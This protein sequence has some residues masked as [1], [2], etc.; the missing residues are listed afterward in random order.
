MKV[1]KIFASNSQE[2]RLEMPTWMLK[3]ENALIRGKNLTDKKGNIDWFN[4]FEEGEGFRVRLIPNIERRV[5][6]TF[7][8]IDFDKHQKYL[9]QSNSLGFRGPDLEAK[10]AADTYRVLIFGDSSSFGWGVD[11]ADTFYSIMSEKLSKQFPGKKFEIANFAI[12]GD[13]SEYGKLIAGKYIPKYESDLVILGFG[14]NDAKKTYI[15]HKI[16]VEKFKSNSLLQNIKYYASYSAIFR[17]LQAALKPKAAGKMENLAKQSA[18]SQKEYAD[19]LNEMAEL[20]RSKNSQVL[21][22]NLCTPGNYAKTAKVLAQHKDYQ[23]FNGQ[24]YL[25]KNLPEIKEKKL[26]PEIVNE[27]EKNYGADLRNDNLL[28]ITSDGCHP[29]KLGNRIIA[30][31]LSNLISHNLK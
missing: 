30:E 29:N 1:E 17:T 6:N 23:Y 28:Y 19:N 8:L 21:L 27:M 24:K 4:I 26:F 13:S 11:Q 22:L 15:K 20:A 3:D 10:K 2:V 14:A 5:S 31:K 25:L 9:V 12:P 7:S 18:V 16:Q